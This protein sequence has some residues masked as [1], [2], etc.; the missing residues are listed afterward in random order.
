MY[1]GAVA[2]GSSLVRVTLQPDG[3]GTIVTLEHS[4]LPDE[5]QRNGHTDGWVHYF[6]RLAVLA[7]GGDPGADPWVTR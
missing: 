2:P 5:E 6:E 7:S 4:G 1:G 3:D